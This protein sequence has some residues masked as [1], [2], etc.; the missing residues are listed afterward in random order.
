MGKHKIEFLDVSLM[1]PGMTFHS[2]LDDWQLHAQYGQGLPCQHLT[3]V[4]KETL[5]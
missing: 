5:D 2:A 4:A 1:I 3:A